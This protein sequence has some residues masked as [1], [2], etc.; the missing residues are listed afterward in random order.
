MRFS[1]HNPY[2]ALLFDGTRLYCFELKTTLSILTYWK[3]EYENKDKKISFNVKSN[4]ILGL[5]SASK[6]NN[7]VCGFV[8]NFRGNINQTYFLNINDF[9]NMIVSLNKKSFN[10]GDVKNNNG[11]LITQTLKRTRYKYDVEKLLT[12]I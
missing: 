6:F 5:R 9:D 8:L 1:L 2:D 12:E 11:V 3:E 7:V 4:Q 10:V